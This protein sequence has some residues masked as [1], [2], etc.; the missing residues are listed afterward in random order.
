MYKYD[1]DLNIALYDG[2]T[3]CIGSVNLLYL[4]VRKHKTVSEK[5]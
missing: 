3:L 2:Y 1:V 4:K 5:M